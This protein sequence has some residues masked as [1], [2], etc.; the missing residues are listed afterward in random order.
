MRQLPYEQPPIWY[1]DN[2][3]YRRLSHPDISP[4][5][6]RRYSMSLSQEDIL[7]NDQ[8]QQIH[9]DPRYRDYR[10]STS[11][12]NSGCNMYRE[13]RSHSLTNFG[14]G[15]LRRPSCDNIRRGSGSGIRINVTAPPCDPVAMALK[16]E[17][18]PSIFVEEYVEKLEDSR[19]NNSADERNIKRSNESV[20]ALSEDKIKMSFGDLSDIPF[21]DD[22]D[23]LAPC[24]YY[25]DDDVI[26]TEDKASKFTGIMLNQS[27][28]SS[29]QCCRK[30]V[31]FDIIS[32]QCTDSM[33]NIKITKSNTYQYF[34]ELNGAI[35]KPKP[36]IPVF[37]FSNPSECDSFDKDDL[38]EDHCILIDQLNNFKSNDSPNKCYKKP[39]KNNVDYRIKWDNKGINLRN[40]N[41][42]RNGRPPVC[43]GKVKALTT[44]F[45]ALKYLNDD[46]CQSTPNLSTYDKDLCHD[47]SDKLSKAEQKHVL[48]QLKEF[49]EF[50]LERQRENFQCNFLNRA[51]STPTLTLNNDD[52]KTCKYYNDVLNRIDRTDLRNQKHNS[53]SNIDDY[54]MH[55][56]MPKC[57]QHRYPD[58]FILHKQDFCRPKCRNVPNR[59]IPPRPPSRNDH[60]RRYTS[61]PVLNEKHR[62]RSPCFNPKKSIK[63]LKQKNQVRQ[64]DF[65]LRDDQEYC[66]SKKKNASSCGAVGSSCIT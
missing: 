30:T 25:L 42:D 51:K 64:H 62:C 50:G 37:E 53:I 28:R 10:S 43:R 40:R 29:G 15:D 38:Q 20:T 58:S 56:Q 8:L 34:N 18:N 16:W 49:S 65:I 24:R 26:E 36:I 44:Y 48:Q 13:R 5:S 12:N 47:E 32:D 7:S 59:S 55:D 54:L 39:D 23:D 45:N 19:S 3:P 33:D 22:E 57:H 6:Q 14:S 60:N 35:T 17:A 27:R 63:K 9:F 66:S 2:D 61:T 4:S 1:N 11:L 52:F 21:I 46:V 41:E 31:S